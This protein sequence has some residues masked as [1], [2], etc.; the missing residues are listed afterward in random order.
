MVGVGVPLVLLLLLLLGRSHRLLLGLPLTGVLLDAHLAQAALSREGHS[1]AHRKG[2]EAALT[3][4]AGLM[5]RFT[6]S[7]H[8][9]QRRERGR[10]HILMELKAK[11]LDGC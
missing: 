7:S 5:V 3:L 9:L 2:L 6:E 8:D 10:K 1:L 4:E 11:D